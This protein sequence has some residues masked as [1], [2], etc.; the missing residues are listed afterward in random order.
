MYASV[1]V[2]EQARVETPTL[3]RE[4][5]T[6]TNLSQIFKEM[7]CTFHTFMIATITFSALYCSCYCTQ[8]GVIFTNRTPWSGA[9]NVNSSVNVPRSV[10]FHR[11]RT[12]KCLLDADAHSLIS[13][14]LRVT[15]A[16]G[17]APLQSPRLNSTAANDESWS[18]FVH[19]S[20]QISPVPSRRHDS[21]QLNSDLTNVRAVKC[22]KLG[23]SSVCTKHCFWY[24]HHWAGRWC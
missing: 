5:A 14:N 13:A 3:M 12:A 2:N 15:G 16:P 1:V 9:T 11:S 4:R 8:R 20:V 24:S 21:R 17:P 10:R 23:K 18:F 22:T 19:T 7:L 6:H